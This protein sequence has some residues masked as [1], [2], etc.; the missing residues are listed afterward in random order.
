MDTETK[1]F[2]FFVRSY[3]VLGSIQVAGLSHILES[4]Q[5]VSHRL[6]IC[7]SRERR[8]LQ[9]QVQLDIGVKVQLQASIS[10]QVR[11][12]GKIPYTCNRLIVDKWILGSDDLKITWWDFCLTR[13][14]PHL[15][16]KHHI[17]L[18]STAFSLIG[19]LL[20]PSRFAC[21]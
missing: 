13:G 16:T 6:E 19:D 8:Q 3:C 10:R 4:V 18:I 21:N 20:G 15:S 9:D 11:V 1:R 7:A 5:R 17:N 12:V 14:F 2:I